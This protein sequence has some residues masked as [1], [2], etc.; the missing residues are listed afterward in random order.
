M[1]ENSVFGLTEEEAAELDS[2]DEYFYGFT[3]DDN[4][5]SCNEV[6]ISGSEESEDEEGTS[7]ILSDSDLQENVISFVSDTPTK[8]SRPAQPDIG[9]ISSESDPLYIKI[10]GR[11]LVFNFMP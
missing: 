8:S 11:M 4:H 10:V 5:I 2:E 1:S 7:G 6:D 3:N 9:V